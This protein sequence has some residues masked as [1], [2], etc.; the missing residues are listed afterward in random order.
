MNPELKLT[1]SPEL[2]RK[3]FEADSRDAAVKLSVLHS[4]I[5]DA[6]KEITTIAAEMVFDETFC[7]ELRRTAQALAP[8]ARQVERLR[9][10]VMRA[11]GRPHKKQPR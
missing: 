3:W 8:L 11:T 6:V 1:V 2:E 7:A 4:A 10:G 5:D 9:T